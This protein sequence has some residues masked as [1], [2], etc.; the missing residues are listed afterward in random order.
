MAKCLSCG[1]KAGFGYDE[2][3]SCYEKRVKVAEAE[4]EQKAQEAEAEA[5][6]KAQEDA[7]QFEQMVA[8]KV[9]A[10]EAS[11]KL[12]LARGEKVTLYK[13]IYVTVDSISNGQ[14]INVFNFAPVVK[15][16]LEGWV[17]QG[18]I[19]K[20]SGFGL[21]NVSYGASSGETWGAGIG[22]LVVAVYVILSKE[23]KSLEYPENVISRR[24]AEDLIR[25]GID[26]EV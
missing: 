19:P 22:G 26:L 21:K 25:R 24:V 23:I 7:A 3:P 13:S 8:Q 1:E 17:V 2:C 15:A 11:A 6:Q 5:E 20:T 16:G 9:N 14:A 18:V 4:A 10:W 12:K